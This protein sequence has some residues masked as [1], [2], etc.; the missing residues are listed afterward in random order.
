MSF[1]FKTH[2]AVW[3][4]MPR[5]HTPSSCTCPLRAVSGRPSPDPQPPGAWPPGPPSGLTGWGLLRRMS[6]DLLGTLTQWQRTHGDVVHLRIW[7]EHQ[8]VLTDPDLARELLVDHHDAL[9]RWERGIRVFSRLHGNS[10]FIYEGNDWRTKRRALQPSFS[11]RSVQA[12]ESAIAATAERS[13]SNWT[14]DDASW[15][16]EGAFTSL[17]MDVILQ[18][19]FSSDIGSHARTVERAVRTLILAANSDL[20]WPASWPLW[21]PWKRRQRQALGVLNELIEGHIRRRLRSPPGAWP[22]DVLSRLL[23]L[24]R[25]DAAAWPL[26]AVRDECMTMFLAGHESTAAT[27]TWWAWCMAANP[28]AQAMARKALRAVPRRS[29]NAAQAPSAPEYLTQTF[30][31]TLRLY[32]TAPVLLSRRAIRPIALGG[33]HF[34][35]RT[36]FLVP[37]QVMHRDSR[38]F[39]EPASFRPERFAGDSPH[40]PRGA[41]MP[42]GA[43]PRVCLGQ[44][45]AMTE[46]TLIAAAILQRFEIAPPDPGHDPKPMFNVSLRPDRPL[47]LKLSA[48]PS[49][50]N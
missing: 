25:E 38:W 13:L 43:G 15:S 18:M 19:M 6:R 14:V 45:L 7:P 50:E 2:A 12:L 9:V 4:R 21:V 49:G 41:F 24:H 44:H 32:T 27:L 40:R 1:A 36:L 39:A 22:E 48:A 47:R 8:I 33:W 10:V 17:A 31:E 28:D 5:M 34:P 20:Y 11:A 46:M 30:E 26:T 42:F 23:Q 37:L 3:R 35:A 16:I 29:T